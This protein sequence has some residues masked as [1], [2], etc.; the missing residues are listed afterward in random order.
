V[1]PGP[2]FSPVACALHGYNGQTLRHVLHKLLNQRLS[3]CI[4]SLTDD[5]QAG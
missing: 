5:I 1:L 4:Q 3:A 2:P